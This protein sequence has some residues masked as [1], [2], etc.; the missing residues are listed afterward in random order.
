MPGRGDGDGGGG[1][2]VWPAVVMVEDV[3]VVI[4]DDVEKTS[5][6]LQ[7]IP[8]SPAVNI[9]ISARPWIHLATKFEASIHNMLTVNTHRRGGTLDHWLKSMLM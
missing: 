6:I 2:V 9:A 3:G 5:W 4:E 7:T 1:V 8:C